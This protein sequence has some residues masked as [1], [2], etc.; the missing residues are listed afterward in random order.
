M[1]MSATAYVVLYQDA[2]SG[3]TSPDI[4]GVDA[5]ETTMGTIDCEAFGYG[6]ISRVDVYYSTAASTQN[7]EFYLASDEADY[8]YSDYA[9]AT[10]TSDGFSSTTVSKWSMSWTSPKYC[11][12]RVLQY[13]FLE[14]AGNVGRVGA[15]AD[16]QQTNNPNLSWCSGT[17]QVCGGGARGSIWIGLQG[18]YATS[19][20]GGGNSTTTYNFYTATTSPT[21]AIEQLTTVHLAFALL[22]VLFLTA[23]ITYTFTYGRS[24]PS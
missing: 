20:G 4:F 6:E 21:E 18:S 16:P 13:R 2:S 5:D 9:H 19:T 11:S 8:Y 24:R 14:T 17:S 1:P 15:I 23:I 22:I 7:W 12:G 3:G 10:R